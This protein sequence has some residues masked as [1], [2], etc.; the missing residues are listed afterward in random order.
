[1]LR[2]KSN[3][4]NLKGGEQYFAIYENVGNVSQKKQI[5]EAIN[6]HN[7]IRIYQLNTLLEFNQSLFMSAKQWAENVVKTGDTK[8]DDNVKYKKKTMLG[9][10]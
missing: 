8:V 10:Y 6:F 7:D 2:L 1:M 4:P 9:C 3:N 5:Q